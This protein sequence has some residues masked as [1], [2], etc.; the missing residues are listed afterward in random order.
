M[1][2]PTFLPALGGLF[3]AGGAATAGTAAGAAASGMSLATAMQ[4][5]AVGVS[6]FSSIAGGIQNANIAKANAAAAQQQAQA[7]RAAGQIEEARTRAELLR[8]M[9]V[10]RAQIAGAG[11]RLDS[12]SSLLLGADAAQ[13]G[14]LDAQAVRYGAASRANALDAEA[15]IYR[16]QARQQRLGGFVSAAGS[17]LNA[18]PTMWQG[19]KGGG[20]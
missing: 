18:P 19:L 12:S 20:A 5:A 8:T 16:A 13:T 9:G 11:A 14:A 6:A 17:V 7:A 2:S 3:S 10:Q 1:C 15:Q 4:A